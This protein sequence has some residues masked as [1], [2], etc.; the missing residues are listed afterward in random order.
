MHKEARGEWRFDIDLKAR[1]ALSRLGSYHAAS[2]S[3]QAARWNAR[4]AVLLG[5]VGCQRRQPS[6]GLRRNRLL[7]A[8]SG[9]VL[10]WRKRTLGHRPFDAASDGLMMQGKSSP[11]AKNG[12]SHSTRATFALVPPDARLASRACN[13]SQAFNLF[14]GQRQLDCVPRRIGLQSRRSQGQRQF[15]RRF[16]EADPG[17]ETRGAVS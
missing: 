16:N 6:L 3:V 2:V 15:R 9:P 5:L 13:G 12:D 17:G 10:E 7:F 14:V 11:T 4:I 8:P 1:S